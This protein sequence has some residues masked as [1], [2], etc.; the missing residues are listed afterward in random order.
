MVLLGL[1]AGHRV[2]GL[3]GSGSGCR[4]MVVVPAVPV[5]AA[6]E[7]GWSRGGFSDGGGDVVGVLL[8]VEVS[9]LDLRRK[10]KDNK[11][12]LI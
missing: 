5:G 6:G 3:V 9:T 12:E 10:G 4:A 7:G 2:G 8:V 1:L 11:S